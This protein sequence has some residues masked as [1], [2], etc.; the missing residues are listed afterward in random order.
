[1]MPATLALR[2]WGGVGAIICIVGIGLP[3]FAIVTWQ[4]IDVAPTAYMTTAVL[5]L[6]LGCAVII[7]TTLRFDLKSR[8]RR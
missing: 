2:I 4:P 7:A 8:Q 5:V 1:M 3:T 6:V